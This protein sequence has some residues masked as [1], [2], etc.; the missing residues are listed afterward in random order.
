[1]ILWLYHVTFGGHYLIKFDK[2]D[3][4]LHVTLKFGGI[5]LLMAW[6]GSE[7]EMLCS[8]LSRT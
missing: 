5:L 3:V 2:V 1:M 8:D 4:K 7:N 6:I